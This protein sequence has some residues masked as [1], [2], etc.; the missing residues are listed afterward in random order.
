M[1]GKRYEN[2]DMPGWDLVYLELN[3][4]NEINVAQSVWSD[5]N[6]PKKKKTSHE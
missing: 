3:L 4:A 5:M 2:I 6:F 1:F